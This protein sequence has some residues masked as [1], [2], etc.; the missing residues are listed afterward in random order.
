VLDDDDDLR[1][2]LV[3]V[4]HE[5]FSVGCLDASSYAALVALGERA[6]A[7]RLAILDINL[8][9]GVPSGIDA[10]R[11]LAQQGFSGEVVFLT[12]HARS[13]PWIREACQIRGARVLEKP[14]SL[15]QLRELVG[16][17]R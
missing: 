4:L 13:H 3:G 11:W 17:A 1:E 14:I 16:A 5:V 15:E 10:Y 7:A 6:H 2:T 12:G 9:P 8:G